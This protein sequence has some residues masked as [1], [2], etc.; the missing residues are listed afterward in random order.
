MASLLIHNAS[1][2]ATATGRYAR[3]IEMNR[4]RLYEHASIFIHDGIIQ[5]I[6]SPADLE[7]MLPPG[8][9]VID[10]TGYT[11]I[12]GL[13]DAHTHLV[14]AGTREKEFALRLSSATYQEIA[15]Q[16]GGILST[17]QATRQASKAELKSIATKYLALALAHGTTTMEVKTGYGLNEETEL[18]LLDVI[19]ELNREQP[20]TLV[21]TFLG[22]HAFPPD[23]TKSEYLAVLHRLLP[24][25]AT[26]AKF[27]DAFVEENYFSH[28]ETERLCLDAKRYG[29]LPRLHVNQFSS[30]GG[31]K[32]G[33]RLGAVSLDHLEN[34]SDEEIQLLAQSETVA[35]LLPCV[36]LF[37]GYGYP[38]ARRLIDAGAITAIASN[39]NPGSAMNLNMQLVMFVACT[40]MSLSPFEALSA[41]T[42]NAAY[43]LGLSEMIGT[44]EIGK[45]ADLLILDTPNFEQAIYFFG[46][47]H[48]K[49]VIK[50]GVVVWTR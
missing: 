16:G 17:V 2:I 10:A 6:G 5:A 4:A 1:Q 8:S 38:P 25:V 35:M 28:E 34:I 14:F 40:Q 33:L 49:I 29:L 43:S 12:P 3:G 13:I 37:L 36:S 18:V 44:I 22:A 11:V 48:S 26:K 7:R 30:N 9:P 50:N 21:P 46:I 15:A 42:L 45:R 31:V 19:E 41:A 20:I 24:R 27:I 23:V 47:N 39:F 32:L